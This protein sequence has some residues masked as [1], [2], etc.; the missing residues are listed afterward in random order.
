M[1]DSQFFFIQSTI[2]LLT[3]RSKL[4][5]TLLVTLRVGIRA[6]HVGHQPLDRYD[7]AISGTRIISGPVRHVQTRADLKLSPDPMQFKV[8]RSGT[9]R[10]LKPGTRLFS[11]NEMGSAALYERSA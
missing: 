5:P 9:D 10:C 6:G 7:P 1:R 3:V 8:E 2:C 4:T 11:G